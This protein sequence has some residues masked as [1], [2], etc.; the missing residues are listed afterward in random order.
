[1]N[2]Q[3]F[4][5]HDI[6][7]C[8]PLCYMVAEVL[9]KFSALWLV[10]KCVVYD[11]IIVSKYYDSVWNLMALYLLTLLWFHCIGNVTRLTWLAEANFCLGYHIYIH[12][13]IHSLIIV[14]Q[15][16]CSGVK[17]RHSKIS[18]YATAYLVYHT[19][20]FHDTEKCMHYAKVKF[21]HW[22]ILQ[23]SHSHRYAF[24]KKGNFQILS[25]EFN[26]CDS[27]SCKYNICMYV[28]FFHVCFI[29]YF[30][31]IKFVSVWKT[32]DSVECC[33]GWQKFLW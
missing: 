31:V 7:V 28:W 14:W 10:N 15:V 33:K 11:T 3:Q 25:M 1:M 17:F 30:S 6:V 9:C 24:P 5:C 27:Y 29:V 23:S 20:P 4:G 16:Q 18:L 12:S 21:I 2:W 22:N 26:N 13:F 32:V 8:T 19:L